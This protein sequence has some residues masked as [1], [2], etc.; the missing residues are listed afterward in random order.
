MLILFPSLHTL[1]QRKSAKEDLEDRIK[2]SSQCHTCLGTLG[3]LKSYLGTHAY[4]TTLKSRLSK[5]RPR[6]TNF[7]FSKV[8][9]LSQQ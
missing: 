8:T 3:T 2:A 6:L 5:T 4:L 7:H 9:D 1:S